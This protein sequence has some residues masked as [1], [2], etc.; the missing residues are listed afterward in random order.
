MMR[1]F[2]FK[3]A[4]L[5]FAVS[6]ALLTGFGIVFFAFAFHAGLERMDREIRT[7]ADSSLHGPRPPEHW[8]DFGKSIQFIYGENTNSYIALLVI[9]EN[10]DILF[11]SLNMPAE[12]VD[13]PRPEVAP[14]PE[15]ELKPETNDP[16][17][18]RLD[19][20][21][22][23]RIS[24]D[25][26]DGPAHIFDHIDTNRDGFLSVEEARNNFDPPRNTPNNS[27]Q[28]RPSID[29]TFHTAETSNGDWRVGTFQD[30]ALTVL[31]SMNMNAFY[32]D[33]NRFR[34]A[35]VIAVPLG[36]ILL[37][38]TSWF[39]AARAMRPVALIA[40]TAE[41]INAKGLDRRIPKV[42]ND[43]ELKRLVT[44]INNMLDRLEKS[45]HQA[46]R[47]SA[48]AAHELQTPLTILQGEL[49]NA[50]QIAADGSDEQQR[51]GMLL[52][53]LSN[54]KAV[55]QKLLLLSHADEGRLKINHQPVDLSG[56]I[57]DA[58]E[59][60][61]IMAPELSIT[62]HIPNAIQ[63]TG[64]AALLNHVLRNMTS[65]AAKYAA[66][67]GCAIFKLEQNPTE[68]RFTLSNTAPP[69]PDADRPL[70]FDRFH[71]VDKARTT[72]G[73]G[74]GLSLAREIARAHG[75]ELSL[76][77]YIDGMVSFTLTLPTT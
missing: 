7:I 24:I 44:V 19:T 48:D 4:M 10:D 16:F 43:N 49:D 41:G 47:F 23:Q 2:K 32:A 63:L 46:I 33:I 13:L 55:V 71:R 58:A 52:E 29:A 73:S 31:I 30:S 45:Y 22:D 77:P 14:S 60:I 65:N 56:L 62:T 25:E 66:Q 69:I 59:D 36:L 38:F 26:F 50:I 76:N 8:Q 40:D 18:A 75:G 64:D 70:L 34:T 6:G 53:E 74:L 54:L 21:N 39:L 1:S 17:I 67:D 72:A 20:N 42:G 37:G 12:L 35:F 27:D 57:R 3:I 61:E 28:R 9:E 68:T 51:Y 15:T 5:S 11:Q